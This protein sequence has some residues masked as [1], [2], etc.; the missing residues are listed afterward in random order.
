M[1][2]GKST[3]GPLLAQVLGWKFIDI[4]TIIEAKAGKTVSEIF[5][6]QGEAHFR[7]LEALTIQDYAARRDVVVALGGG[8]IE[9]ESTRDLL[10]RFGHL[11]MIFLNAPLDVL[12]ARC[13]AQPGAAE[14]PVLAD[15]E[16]LSRRMQARLPYY[17][18][19]HLTITTSG[20][21]PPRVVELILEELDEKRALHATREGISAQ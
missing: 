3:I 5:A 16:G 1:G 19:A 8:A 10:A 17:C 15:R 12:V 4:D 20:L 2:A 13:I 21:T 18:A 9:T 7:E 14:R 11:R 6:Q